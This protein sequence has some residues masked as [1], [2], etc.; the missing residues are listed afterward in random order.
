MT[1]N[2]R[3]LLEEELPHGTSLQPV[4]LL[5]YDSGEG[6]GFPQG[7]YAPL[8]WH[9]HME[10]LYFRRGD[11][12]VELNLEEVL[13]REGDIAIINSG[14]LHQI[15]SNTR[16]SSHDV[17]LF[18][19]KI[20]SF[21]YGDEL[22]ESLLAPLIRQEYIFPGKIAS[23]SP[24]HQEISAIIRQLIQICSE[25]QEHWYYYAKLQVLFLLI[26]LQEVGGL[27]PSKTVLGGLERERIDKYKKIISYMEENYMHP[28]SLA[29]L[30]EHISCNPQYLCHFFKKTAGVSPVD[31]LIRL[32]IKK[33]KT[34]LKESN[35]SVLEIGMEC[36]FDNASY[37]A[38]QFRRHTGHS[39]REYRNLIQSGRS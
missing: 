24:L 34:M 12:V 33:A 11:F 39:P 26:R 31:Y 22:Q 6:T 4:E 19:P 5:H 23:H 21:S 18:D 10:I 16:D 25:K 32:R 13:F 3:Y 20:L 9:N 38:R 15:V 7:Y 29:Q 36:G 8:H 30:A 1:A 17:L 28:I 14:Q 37:F 27:I 2:M 35:L